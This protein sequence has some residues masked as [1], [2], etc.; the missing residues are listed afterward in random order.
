MY[1]KSVREC[2]ARVR[3]AHALRIYFADD[4]RQEHTFSGYRKVFFPS[5]RQESRINWYLLGIGLRL[6]LQSWSR[7]GTKQLRHREDK[8]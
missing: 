6:H 8:N 7:A 3:I 2:Y 4:F 1:T 5:L